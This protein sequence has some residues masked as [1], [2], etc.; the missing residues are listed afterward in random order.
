MKQRRWMELLKDYNYDILYH[1]G[2]ANKVANALSRK[3]SVAHLLIKEWNLIERARDLVFKFEVGHLL[4]LMATLRIEPDIQVKIKLLQ[5]TD[6]DVHK[7]IQENTDKRNADFQ[8]SDDGI[9]RF[10]GR[11]VVPDDVELREDILSEAHCRSYNVHPRSIKLQYSTSYHPQIDGQSKRTIQTL[12]D[13]LRACVIDFK[14]S[15]EDQLYMVEF[16]YNNSYQ[17]SIKMAPFEALY[18]RL[19]RMPVCWDEVGEIKI[20]GS[21]LV[22]QSVKAV[23]VIRDRLKTAK[24]K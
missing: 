4:S 3:S 9:L 12:E 21:E 18:G 17:R 1:P 5:P 23:A 2:K 24:R 6:P 10:R 19:C 20:T 11:L 14:G 15:W 7:I 13:M 16:A 8:V 22:Q